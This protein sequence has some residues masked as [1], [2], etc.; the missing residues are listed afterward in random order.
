MLLDVQTYMSDDILVK[1]DRASM[2]YALEAC[3]PLLDHRVIEYAFSLPHE[4]AYAKGEKKRILKDILYDYV[5]KTLMDRP[6]KGFS[7]PIGH[8]LRTTKRDLL[9]R[10]TDEAMLGE[11]G[12]FQPQAVANLIR[13]FLAGDTQQED[14]VWKYCMFQ[15]W[16]DRYLQA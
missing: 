5:P 3:C 7:I 2:R 9:H 10:L 1:V 11:Q 13:S 14:L 15:Q 4:Y 8:Y 6:K 12:I 16:Y